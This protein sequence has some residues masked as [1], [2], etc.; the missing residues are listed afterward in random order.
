MADFAMAEVSVIIPTF[1]RSSMVLRALQSVLE[2]DY[3]NFEIIVIDDGSSDDTRSRIPGDGRIKLLVHA[4]NRGV[5][6]ARNTGIRY[7]S[8]RF[9]AFLDSDDYWL[10]AKL[11][12]QMAFFGAHP[13]AVACQTEEKWIRRGKKVSPQKRHKKPSGDIFE[14]SLELCVVSPSSVMLRRNLFDEVG[15]FDE[16]LPACEDYDLWLRIACRHPIHLI[17][18]ELSVREGG[19]H[20]QLSAAFA[21]MD[22]FRIRSLVK[23]LEYSPLTAWQHAAVVETLVRKS[24]IYANGCI[25]RGRVEEGDFFHSLSNRVLMGHIEGNK[26][27]ATHE[28]PVRFLGK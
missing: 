25:K 1:N 10:P 16:R 17:P 21:G 4:S 18:E 7:C 15:L 24:K 12:R 28:I 14:R 6:A 9:I 8:G 13:S 22:L 2:Q 19:R 23:L 11:A 3:P 20:D 5:S 26:A 27:V